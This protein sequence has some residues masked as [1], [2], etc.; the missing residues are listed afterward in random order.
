MLGLGETK[1]QIVTLLKDLRNADCDFLTIGQ[2]MAPSTKHYPV[3]EYVRPEFFREMKELAQDMGFSHV[4][5]G[6]FVRS[7]YHAGE[8]IGL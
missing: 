6:P 5:S 7:S 8:A 3:K 2:Y 4:A 1:E